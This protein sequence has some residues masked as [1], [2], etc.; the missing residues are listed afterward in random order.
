VPAKSDKHYDIDICEACS[1]REQALFGEMDST[2]GIGLMMAYLVMA[3]SPKGR[4]L[5]VLRRNDS[6]KPATDHEAILLINEAA[7]EVG[8]FHTKPFR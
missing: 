2:G 7:H 1:G 4:R 6:S 5:I 8:R 3:N